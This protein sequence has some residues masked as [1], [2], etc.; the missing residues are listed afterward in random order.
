MLEIGPESGSPAESAGGPSAPPHTAVPA[1]SEGRKRRILVGT[2]LAMFLAALDQTIIVTALP[3]IGAEFSNVES[4]T[5]VMTSYLL[6]A[7][8][9]VPLYGKFSDIY[10]R[11]SALLLGILT[12]TVGSI[13]CAVAPNLNALII[14][15]AL[16]GLGGGGLL[17]VPQTIIGDIIPPRERGRYQAYMA[18]THAVAN[19]C[20]PVLGGL[21]AEYLHWSLVFW[22]NL[23][24]AALALGISL[25]VMAHLPR[26]E[27]KHR[28]DLLG[29]ALL[30]SATVLLLIALSSGGRQGWYSPET[31]LTLSGSLALWGLAAARI[32]TSSEPLIPLAVL[33]DQVAAT[34]TFGAFFGMG[35]YVGLTMAI[36]IFFETMLHFSPSQSGLAVVPL[37]LGAVVGAAV[38]GRASSRFLHYKRVP[39]AGLSA[40][41]AAGVLLAIFVDRLPLYVVELLLISLSVGIGTMMPVSLVAL[42]NSVQSHQ[43]GTATGM[44]V[45]A[46]QLG[47]AVVVAIYGAII[48]SAV[49][50]DALHAVEGGGGLPAEARDQLATAFRHVFMTGLGGVALAFAC[51]LAMKEKP[52]RGGP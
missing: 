41:V 43:L 51:F 48:F 39:I 6:T 52:L 11:R 24:L 42:Q 22:I 8:A 37:T 28:L 40:G 35:T 30:C 21:F 34:S 7:T 32:L 13:A 17:A 18:G 26:N 29:A 47:G 25:R 2:M 31:I 1:L 19:L 46:R 33:T 49:D 38:S 36:P 16:Q 45:F 9:G 20:G 10:G 4:L 23:P 15:R 27:R 5:W 44:M 50:Q 12:F 14:A 3:T